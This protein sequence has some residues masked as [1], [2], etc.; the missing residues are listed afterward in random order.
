MIYKTFAGVNTAGLAA[1]LDNEKTTNKLV[2][3]SITR[4]SE[5]TTGSADYI[6]LFQGQK[7]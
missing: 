5:F 1:A 4:T 7:L 2:P 3:V 6:V